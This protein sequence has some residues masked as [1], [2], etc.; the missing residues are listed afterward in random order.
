MDIKRNNNLFNLYVFLTTFSRNLLEVFVGTILYKLGF[1]LH[2]VVFYYLLV[3]LFSLILAVP[4]THISKKYSNKLLSVMGIMSFLGLQ[5][6]LNY[7][8]KKMIFIYIIAF[9]FALYRRAYWIARRYYTMQIIDDKKNIAS[10]YSVISILNQLGVIVS[11]YCGALFLQ[12]F[13]IKVITAISIILLGVSLVLLYMI[14]FE[15]EKNDIKLNLFETIKCTPKSSMLN[16]S[17]YEMQNVIKFLFPLFIIIY[18]KNTYTAIGI[19]NLLANI[20]SLI[21]TYVY[22]R[23][24]N[25]KKNFLKFSI[26]FFLL[27][28]LLQINT[29]G[30]LLLILSF[31]EGFAS[32]MYEQSFHKEHFTL[33]KSFE[34]ANYN[35]MYEMVMNAS[36]LIVVV[37]LYL[38]IKDIKT[39]LYIT[40][41]I[42]SLGLVFNFKTKSRKKVSNVLWVE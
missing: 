36:R 19:V 24:I 35:Y 10:R 11:A 14:N 21:F 31:V 29:S 40:I 26:F 16:I 15:Y 9:L 4:C 33:S 6:A 13:S 38:F 3:N 17:C 1:S 34:Y 12:F 23:L 2:Q 39:M 27:I 7:V 41:G 42:M 18:I 20:A 25:N 8:K 5:V 22:G 32:R 37:F 30:M 28:K